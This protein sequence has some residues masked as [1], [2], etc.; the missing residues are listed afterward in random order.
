MSTVRETYK[1][2]ISAPTPK[3][4]ARLRKRFAKSITAK[5]YTGLTKANLWRKFE[6]LVPD[7]EKDNS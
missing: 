7:P 2:L 5:G 3:K 6:Q 4:Y 1:R